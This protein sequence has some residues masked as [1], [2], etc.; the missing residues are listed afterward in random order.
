M[1]YEEWEKVVLPKN[2]KVTFKKMSMVKE[3]NFKTA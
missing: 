1:S 3:V 2:Q